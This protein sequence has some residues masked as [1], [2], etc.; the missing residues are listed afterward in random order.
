MTKH[1]SLRLDD[2]LASFIEAVHRASGETDAVPYLP[3]STVM[4]LLMRDAARR[5]A[6]GDGIEIG[7][8][9]IDEAD[10]SAIVPDHTIARY[11]REDL[12]DE[13]WL[14]DMREGFEGRVRNQL[15]ERFKGGYDPEGIAAFAETFT[16]EAHIYWQVIDEDDETYQDKVAFV[17]DKI[18]QY[19]EK[20]ETSTYDP[21]EEWL[22]SFEGV[23]DGE[24][25]QEREQVREQAKANL[26]E[27]VEDAKTLLTPRTTGTDLSNADRTRDTPAEVIDKLSARSGVTRDVAEEAV[28][29]ASR[30]VPAADGGEI[31]E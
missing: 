21:D 3:Q 19:R 22:S 2:D 20:W 27:L 23:E 10:L 14:V 8:D 9:E 5:V 18:E 6:D 7:F 25:E 13:T 16:R 26:D 11:L 4:Q 15:A 29:H 28:E 30:M 12:K 31:D 1:T 24:A 17:Q